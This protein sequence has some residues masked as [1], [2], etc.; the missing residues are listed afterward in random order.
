MEDINLDDYDL[1]YEIQYVQL[2][3]E[4][5]K[6]YIKFEIIQTRVE[7]NLTIYLIKGCGKLQQLTR[8]NFVYFLQLDF[9]RLIYQRLKQIN[10]EI[11]SEIK[12][13]REFID[14][15]VHNSKKFLSISELTKKKKYYAGDYDIKRQSL[16]NKQEKLETISNL[17]KKY[18]G[19]IE[20]VIHF[21][22]LI[23]TYYL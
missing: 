3:T 5:L 15:T 19:K 9:P 2:F 18:H 7:P 20:N 13:H 10:D 8:K 22:K 4:M 1:S 6:P 16:R 21:L 12:G 14:Y 17:N 11:Q 23:E